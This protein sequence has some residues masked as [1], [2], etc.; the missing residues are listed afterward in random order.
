VIDQQTGLASQR[1]G[2]VAAIIRDRRSNLNVDTQREVPRAVVDELLGLAVTAPN[3]YRT[4]PWRFAVLTG[5]ARRRIGQV[6]AKALE[7]K[8]GANE[9]LLERQRTQFLRA[10]VVV[11]A[12]SAPDPDPIK[13]FENKHTVAAGVQ[14]LLLGATA[15]GLASAWRSG[16]A[17]V[18]PDVSSAVKS[19]VGIDD[20]DEIV[21]FVYLGWPTGEPGSREVP[22]PDVRY[23]T[24]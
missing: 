23:L 15:M 4:H 11:V 24:D 17:M 14:N 9:A 20:A 22:E 7:E 10:P 5:E 16:A 8:G 13:D 1:F 3:H 6:A 21:A 19:A 12:A 18:D 2:E